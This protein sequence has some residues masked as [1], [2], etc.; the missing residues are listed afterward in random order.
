MARTKTI[1]LFLYI[2]F[3]Y[4]SNEHKFT[5]V[6]GRYS[7][8][9]EVVYRDEDDLIQFVFVMP[10]THIRWMTFKNSD[11]QR[12]E[13]ILRAEAEIL[14]S[15]IRRLIRGLQIRKSWHAVDIDETALKAD[16]AA[17]LTI[18]L[19]ALDVQGGF[20]YKLF[21]I[22]WGDIKYKREDIL[23]NKKGRIISQ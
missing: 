9:N 4:K 7:Y 8:L 6:D 16:L 3:F 23:K 14:N 15:F 20:S 11:E 2:N 21:E 1:I 22:N 5:N 19:N 17:R 18:T 12:K 13:K 10:N